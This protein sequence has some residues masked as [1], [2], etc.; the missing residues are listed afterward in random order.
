VATRIC[1]L[2]SATK[3]KRSLKNN[4]FKNALGCV[5]VVLEVV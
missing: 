1:V 5:P 2:P 3:L 4:T